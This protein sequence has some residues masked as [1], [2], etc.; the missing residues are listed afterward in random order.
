MLPGDGGG[1]GGM[2]ATGGGGGVQG[3]GCYMYYIG[4]IGKTIKIYSCL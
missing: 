2:P 3:G 4:F 1:G